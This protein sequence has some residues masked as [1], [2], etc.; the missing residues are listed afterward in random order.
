[1]SRLSYFGALLGLG[2]LLSASLCAQN[3]AEIA[4]Q[5]TAVSA[6]AQSRSDSAASISKVAH[7]EQVLVHAGDKAD[8]ALTV[9]IVTSGARTAPDTQAITGPDRIV[10]DFP[11]ALPAAALHALTVNQG[12]LK[13]IRTGL[14][15]NDPPITRVVLDLAEPQ[16]YQISTTWSGTIITLK[17]VTL[18]L[19]PVKAASIKSDAVRP[20][21][22][23]LGAAAANP[24]ANAAANLAANPAANPAKTTP[25][26]FSP[27]KS[28][29]VT[30]TAK[31]DSATFTLGPKPGT[32]AASSSRTTEIQIPQASLV[33]TAR[34]PSARIA[35]AAKLPEAA[36][37]AVMP[38]AVAV[39]PHKVAPV[40]SV[41][42]A[43]PVPVASA[44]PLLDPVP[45]ELPEPPKPVVSVAFANGMLSIHAERATLAQVLFEVQRQ[46]QADIAIPAG[47]EQEEVIA[48]LGPA[49][50]RDVLGS[51][52]NGSNYN[53]IFVG[54]E[55]R[56]ERVIL[57]RRDPNI[58]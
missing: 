45:G 52:L 27:V 58:F 25:V 21:P 12:A 53:F 22:A 51:L 15:F 30:G 55:E 54:S 14:F 34:I 9:E 32:A 57:T 39:A 13:G 19:D 11:G 6:R 56:L 1:M 49:S 33:P 44:A 35:P 36:L 10:V 16:S 41:P 38:A 46:T 18:N 50:A 48:D 8:A 47:A 43:I 17:P 26:A 37:A 31:L 40:V 5:T 2:A 7:V 23:N 42:P 24:V 20:H 4:V 29:P 3:P 28:S